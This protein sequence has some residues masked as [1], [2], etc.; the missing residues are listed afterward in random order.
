MLN[1]RQQIIFAQKRNM[2]IVYLYNALAI[3]GGLERIIIDKMN[4]LA[5]KSGFEVF[6]V[7]WEQGSHPIAFPLSPKVVHTDL[8]VRFFTLYKYGKI[9]RFFRHYQ[10]K[11]NYRR[12]VREKMEEIKP[13]IILLTTFTPEDI[14]FL[15]KLPGKPGIIVESHIKKSAA[16]KKD[17]YREKSLF[18]SVLSIYDTF[19]LRKIRKC[20]AL[21]TL[22]RNDAIEWN[23]VKPAIVIP[24]MLTC[25]PTEVQ[26][27]KN[28]RIIS[29]GRLEEQ[30]GYD[31]L[32][33]AWALVVQKHP[34]WIIDIYGDGS[35]KDK[36]IAEIQANGLEKS[37]RIHKPTPH[38]FEK[39]M[40]SA[41]Y[42]MSS[43]VE[44]FGL[45]LTEAMSCGIPC[46]SFD[47][48]HGPSDI[49]RN[50]EDG[51]LVENGNIQLLA[52]K[53][54]YLIE[55]EDIRTG[56]GPKAREN[57]KRFL[58]ENIMP[59]WEELFKKLIKEKKQV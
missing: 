25:Y 16:G 29:A 21:V 57:V 1:A 9:K 3:T 50:N 8:N 23:R 59:A 14:D 55:N 28:K 41:F 51:I 47:C 34:D 42:V 48:P 27:N 46:I 33:S 4:Y 35:Q 17:R 7:T 39:Y 36:L 52:E 58:P 2:R 13:D 53:I 19:Q 43:R 45:V 10:M 37:F 54:C 22:T 32:I 56:M 18:H 44:G 40:E 6:I 15:T 31:M 20:N 24:N 38:I 30:K 49:I 12:L 26:L 11:R 5:E